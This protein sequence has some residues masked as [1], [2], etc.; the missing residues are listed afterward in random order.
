MREI[1][2]DTDDDIDDRTETAAILEYCAGFSRQEAE[3]RAGLNVSD[4]QNI[5]TQGREYD[6]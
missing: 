2:L 6:G 5:P 3:R 1:F 4:V